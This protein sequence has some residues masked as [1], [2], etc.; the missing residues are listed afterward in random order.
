MVA[1]YVLDLIFSISGIRSLYCIT[2][3]YLKVR[4][5]GLIKSKNVLLYIL[6]ESL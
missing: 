6:M 5:L 1:F 3:H 2:K 4:L